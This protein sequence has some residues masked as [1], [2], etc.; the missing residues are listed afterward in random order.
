MLHAEVYYGKKSI[1]SNTG[2]VLIGSAP[3][4]TIQLFI[5]NHKKEEVLVTSDSFP[6]HKYDSAIEELTEYYGRFRIGEHEAED[7]G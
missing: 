3:M 6:T 5:R 2:P 4:T 7:D 1:D